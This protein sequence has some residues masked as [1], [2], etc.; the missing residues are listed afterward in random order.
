MDGEAFAR[1]IRWERER[2]ATVI[3]QANITVD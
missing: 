1:L 2:W 3:R